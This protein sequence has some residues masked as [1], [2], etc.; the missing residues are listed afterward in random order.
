MATLIPKS[1]RVPH[2]AIPEDKYYMRAGSSFIPV[3]HAV[4][5][6]MFG[7][8]PQPNLFE[9]YAINT[10]KVMKAAGT[11]PDVI[12]TTVAFRIWNRG[13]VMARDLYSDIR[14]T[15]P[16]NGNVHFAN[17]D[18]DWISGKKSTTWL[19]MVSKN[20]FKLAPE[21]FAAVFS[22]R[23]MIRPPFEGGNF[24]L[25]WSFGCD[26]SPLKLVETQFNPAKIE[27]IYKEFL[28]GPQTRP[29]MKKFVRD[30]F[31]LSHVEEDDDAR[32]EIP[33]NEF[34]PVTKR[35]VRYRFGTKP[36]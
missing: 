14:V 16:G 33:A 28:R 5:A 22:L 27:Q 34:R 25:R 17:M 19:S 35:P 11:R 18:D 15:L 30:L 3:P 8:R 21:S 24:S 6:G 26:G 9:E 13:P 12:D 4:L 20:E 29:E 31:N 2:Q 7:K 32:Q 36:R 23:A 1:E 10:V